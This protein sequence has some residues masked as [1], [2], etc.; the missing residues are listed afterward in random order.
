MIRVLIVDDQP[1]VLDALRQCFAL[2]PDLQIV[3][4]ANDGLGAL[5][6]AQELHPDIVLTDIKMPNMDGLTATRA[7]HRME[8]TIKVIILSIYDDL[9]TRAQAFSAGA[10]EFVAKHDPAETLIAAIRQAAGDAVH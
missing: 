8:P 6:L 7:L 1:S 4:R 5:A 3:G 2:E 9:A 10:V